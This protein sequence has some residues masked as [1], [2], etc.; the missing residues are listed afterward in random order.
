MSEKTQIDPEA[1]MRKLSRRS[2]FWAGGAILGAAGFRQ[3]LATRPDADGVPRPFRSALQFNEKVGRAVFRPTALA[4]EF[5]AS[6]AG[7]PRPNGGIGLDSEL[8][9]RDWELRVEGSFAWGESRA[10]RRKDLRIIKELPRVEMTTELKC[11]EGWSQVVTWAGARFSD[12][13]AKYPP[14]NTKSGRPADVLQ[15]PQD[16]PDYVAIATPDGKYYVGLDRESALHPQTLLCYEMNGKPLTPEHGAPLR[17]VIPVKY[18]IKN[19]KRIGVIRY[20][21]ERPPDYW[22]EAGYD[23]YAGL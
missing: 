16:L 14:Q 23:W 1:Q 8:D 4:P 19:I 10:Y 3:W 22:A 5:P 13:M 17:L 21:N 15:R 20:T 9:L 11:I 7:E 18:G 12:F 6:L 2:L